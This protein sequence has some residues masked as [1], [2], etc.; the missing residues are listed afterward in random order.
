MLLLEAE[1]NY[2]TVQLSFTSLPSLLQS[3]CSQR[4]ACFSI[5]RNN[6]VFVIRWNKTSRK[7]TEEGCSSYF[8]RKNRLENPF[9][10]LSFCLA[11]LRFIYRNYSMNNSVTF[12]SEDLIG[13][14]RRWIDLSSSKNNISD[15]KLRTTGIFR[16]ITLSKAIV[17]GA[18]DEYSADSMPFPLAKP[19]FRKFKRGHRNRIRNNS[20][21]LNWEIYQRLILSRDFSLHDLSVHQIWQ[22]ASSFRLLTG[23]N[24]VSSRERGN[25]RAR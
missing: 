19:S 25:P 20:R 16:C 15:T 9:S 4:A 22:G 11:I 18:L 17:S 6:R 13:I 8:E 24:E 7:E 1:E 10:S 12:I 3:I 14:E 5:F 21:R 2:E 23:Y